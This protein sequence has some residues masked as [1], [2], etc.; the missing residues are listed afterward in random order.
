MLKRARNSIVFK[1]IAGVVLLLTIFSLIVSYIGY[2]GFT[3]ALLTQYADDGFRTA[4]TA[5][6]MVDPDRIDA[7]LE[8][9]GVTE[10]Y[11]EVREEM[12]AFCNSSGVTFIYVIVPDRTDYGH[13]TFVIS[14]INSERH[15]TEYEFGYVR[16]TTNDDYRRKYKNLYDQVSDEELVIR[17]KGYIE[18][19]PHITAM[20]P[21]IGSDGETKAILCVQRQM[22]NL[23]EARNSYVKNVLWV[24]ANLALFAIVG[25]TMFLHQTLLFPVQKITEEAQRFAEENVTSGK[26]L[27]EIILNKD[28]IGQLASSIDR[29]EEQIEQYVDDLTRVTAEKERIGAE[30][31]LASRIQE[32]MLPNTFPAFPDREEFDIYAMMD[33]AREVGGDFY[34]F[35]LVDDDHLCMLIAD[36]SGK[37]IPAALFMMAAKIIL[38]NHAMMGE[39]PA[40]ILE[41]TNDT[42]V[43][44]NREEMFVTVWLGILE[45]STGKLIAANAGHEYPVFQYP[46]ESFDLLKDKHGFIIGGMEDMKYK[47]YAMVLEPGTKLFLYTDG[48]P[49]A[50]DSEERMFGTGRVVETLN[51]EPGGTPEEILCRV[52]AAVNGFV[53]EAEQ[54]D[55][56][57]M[58][59]LEYKGG[60]KKS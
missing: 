37:G 29:M 13:I 1:S 34:D 19:E 28:E 59:C 16:E 44:N 27:E 18:S 4:D 12:A 41:N 7:Y 17:D 40:Q 39:S 52:K 33:P 38:A 57:T 8:S 22:D 53:K 9:G 5:A 45:L 48:L 35:F 32:N 20:V 43:A 26:K 23:V 50:T 31:S 58:L 14:T 60:M 15:F 24:L 55:D 46:G 6:L 56:L 36:V 21:L 2:T 30:L 49:E 47:E 10:E 3:D 11:T 42:I 51:E 54:F 25:F